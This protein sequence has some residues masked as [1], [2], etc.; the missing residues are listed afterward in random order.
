MNMNNVIKKLLLQLV[1]DIDA[2]NSNITEEEAFQ[3][4]E[5]LK[6][7][8]DPYISKYQA[9]EQIGISRATFD[10]L[11]REGKIPKGT[12]RKGFKEKTKKKCDILKYIANN[13]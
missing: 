8:S 9:C 12:K 6:A 10:N 11:I 7:I 4:I 5:K 1:D 2:G 3:I 13:K